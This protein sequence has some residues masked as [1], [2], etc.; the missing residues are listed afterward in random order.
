MSLKDRIS[1][2]INRI[3]LQ[4]DHFAETHYWNGREILCV[5][6][7]EEALKRKNNNV[8][9]ISWDSNTRKILIHVSEKDFPGIEEAMEPNAHIFFDRK[10]MRVLDIN[11][12]MGMLD[13]LLEA[14]DP[15]EV[16]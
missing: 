10:P 14:R 1:D 3:F 4:T 16:L 5:T 11:I 15:R 7:E 9:D 6:D 12:N 2:D 8:N 13:I